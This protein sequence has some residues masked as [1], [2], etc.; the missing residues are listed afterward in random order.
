MVL[1]AL[2]PA[3]NAGEPSAETVLNAAGIRHGF[4]VHIDASDGGLAEALAKN[5][6]LLMRAIPSNA[7]AETQLRQRFVKAGVHGQVTAVRLGADAAVPLADNVASLVVADLDSATGVK[8][9]GIFRVL[10]PLGDAYLKRDGKWS[11]SKKPRP[12]DV[13]DWPRNFHDAS[14]SDLSADRVSGPAR[15]RALRLPLRRGW[16]LVRAASG[17]ETTV[18]R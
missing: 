8:S 13:D 12:T 9:V 18:R 11:A 16:R 1:P 6:S 10:R 15:A 4:V 14:M 5:D 3:S 7:A 2:I 17:E